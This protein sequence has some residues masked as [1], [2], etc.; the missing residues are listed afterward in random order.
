MKISGTHWNSIRDKFTEEEKQE[1]R[2]A[3]IGKSICPMANIIDDSILSEE[4]L[5]KLKEAL[6]I[7][8]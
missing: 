6:G 8:G 4:L 7:K 5:K 3:T 1:L 2:N